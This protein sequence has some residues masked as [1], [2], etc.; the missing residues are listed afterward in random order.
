MKFFVLKIL[1]FFDFFYKRKVLKA[2]K[3]LLSKNNN[4]IFDVGGHHGESI[5]FF[6]ENFNTSKIYTFEP[7]EDNFLKLKKRTKN[8]EEKVFGTLLILF[9]LQ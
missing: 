5:F 7:I 4:V 8:I 9:V 2:L 1:M 3:N 6:N